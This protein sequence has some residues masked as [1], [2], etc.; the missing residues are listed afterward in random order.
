[1]R[2][3][4]TKYQ[5]MRNTRSFSCLDPISFPELI[6]IYYC[7]HQH[8]YIFTIGYRCQKGKVPKRNCSGV[9]CIIQ[10]RQH[11]T[12]IITD[13]DSFHGPTEQT[14]RTND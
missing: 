2:Y 7:I 1:M 11:E 12:F 10:P 6:Y 8:H 3:R 14:S 13:H 9:V 5:S 4:T